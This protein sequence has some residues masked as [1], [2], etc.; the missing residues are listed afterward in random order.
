MRTRKTSNGASSNTF[1]AV[2]S[3]L[4]SKTAQKNAMLIWWEYHWWEFWN[5]LARLLQDS[6]QKS[7][8]FLSTSVSTYGT[9]MVLAKLI[10][11]HLPNK[12]AFQIQDFTRK[13]RWILLKVSISWFEDI[14]RFGLYRAR[15]SV[16]R[17]RYPRVKLLASALALSQS[18]HKAVWIRGD[19]YVEARDLVEQ[20]WLSPKVFHPVETPRSGII[21]DER[22]IRSGRLIPNLW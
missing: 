9:E 13:K 5:I 20:T 16:C 4:V 7:R 14:K 19:T 18:W 8:A 6:L 2:I 11:R 22:K 3:G 10:T 15:Y 1:S 21:S 17:T 12:L